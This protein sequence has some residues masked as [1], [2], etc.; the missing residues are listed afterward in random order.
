MSNKA[1]NPSQREDLSRAQWCTRPNFQEGISSQLSFLD[2]FIVSLELL[3]CLSLHDLP[4]AK[5]LPHAQCGGPATSLPFLGAVTVA[6]GIWKVFSVPKELGRAFCFDEDINHG[7]KTQQK[8]LFKP[9][10]GQCD[11]MCFWQNRRAREV[12]IKSASDN[13]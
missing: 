6:T 12:S 8:P 2:F 10:S 5:P 13:A 1:I 9:F 11:N 4:L 7:I 3:L